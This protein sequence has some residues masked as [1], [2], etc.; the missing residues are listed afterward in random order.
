MPTHASSEL[1]FADL[2]VC[3]DPSLHAAFAIGARV[4]IV[5]ELRADLCDLLPGD[6]DLLRR[7]VILVAR[8][9]QRG[10]RGHL[11]LRQ[12]RLAVVFALCEVGVRLRQLL[13][14]DRL[15]VLRLQAFDLLPLG[16]ERGLG[17]IERDAEGLFVDAEQYLVLCDMLVVAD[18]DRDDRAGHLGA[19]RDVVRADIGVI[20]RDVAA[21][22]E[23]EEGADG[24]HQQRHDQEKRLA[25][26]PAARR[27][28]RRRGLRLGLGLRLGR[29]RL[30]RR[31]FQH[32]L[33]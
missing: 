24:D 33:A 14:F 29:R 25:P 21:A 32:R 13:G 9:I 30:C 1:R 26:A 12:L 7:P 20:G 16:A 22:G 31:R 3:N 28:G 11:R 15:A 10:F 19:D 8:G 5:A 27:G 2:V 17:A 4:G 6:G 18:R 23:I